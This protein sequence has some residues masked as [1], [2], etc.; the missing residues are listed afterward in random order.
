MKL[1]S[2][3]TYTSLVY[4]WPST[5]PITC[6]ILHSALSSGSLNLCSH[7]F[8]QYK[9][10]FQLI[11][12]VGWE[13]PGNVSPTWAPRSVSS[14]SLRSATRE[15]STPSTRRSPPSPLPKVRITKIVVCSCCGTGTGSDLMCRSEFIA[16]L[17]WKITGIF[18]ST[19]YSHPK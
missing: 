15:S 9:P 4:Q 16:S 11:E 1:W 10:L 2:L 17:F 19:F 14:A 18:M 12:K 3:L 6:H 8:L 7:T 13:C 5:V